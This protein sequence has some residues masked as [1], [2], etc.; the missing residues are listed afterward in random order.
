MVWPTASEFLQDDAQQMSNGSFG[1]IHHDLGHSYIRRGRRT[2]SGPAQ[3]AL[4]L[5]MRCSLR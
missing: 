5:R 4:P 2:C 1:I 3:R